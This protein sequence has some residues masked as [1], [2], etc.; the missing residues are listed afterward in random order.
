MNNI[1]AVARDIR[2]K[3]LSC[4]GIGGAELDAYV[5][6]YW[7]CEAANRNKYGSGLKPA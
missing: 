5:D 7:H 1:E 6:R 3:Q 4:P 2:S